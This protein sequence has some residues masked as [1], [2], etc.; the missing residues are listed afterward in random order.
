MS[1][2]TIQIHGE[3]TSTHQVWCERDNALHAAKGLGDYLSYTLTIC[4]DNQCG[5]MGDIHTWGLFC[6]FEYQ[7][8]LI[9]AVRKSLDAEFKAGRKAAQGGES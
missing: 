1:E 3:D 9:D 2:F 4:E 8:A 6:I 5:G 7:E